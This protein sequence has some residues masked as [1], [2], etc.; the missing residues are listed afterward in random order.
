MRKKKT[1]K[2]AVKQD[3]VFFRLFRTL[4]L[5]IRFFLSVIDE[6]KKKK[7][8]LYLFFSFAFA[9]NNF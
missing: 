7:K 1:T 9:V 8:D 4:Y 2:E 6:Q 3:T 5:N